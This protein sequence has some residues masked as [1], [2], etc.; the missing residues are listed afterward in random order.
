MSMVNDKDGLMKV[1]QC[2]AATSYTVAVLAKNASGEEA[3]LVNSIGTKSIAEER[4]W[5]LTKLGVN[6]NYGPTS[7]K[8]IASFMGVNIVGVRYGLFKT[9]N[10]GEIPI[11]LYGKLVAEHGHDVSEEQLE[12]VGEPR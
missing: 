10:I 5:F 2:N 3:L 7:E 9:E 4:T 12:H 11:D 6:E 1:T 8:I